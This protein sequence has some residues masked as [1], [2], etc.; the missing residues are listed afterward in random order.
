MQLK[1]LG[2]LELSDTS[3]TRVK[4][5]LLL[6]YLAVEGPK[7]RR[8]I[9]EL[10]WMGASDPLNS[11]SR[12]LSQLRKGASGAIEADDQRVWTSL[13]TDLNAFNEALT[14]KNYPD[15]VTHYEGAF[16]QGAHL[17][18]WGIELEE[19]IFEKREHYATQAQNALLELAEQHA[20]RGRFDDAATLAE[21][22]YTLE[23]ATES[24]PEDLPRYF[25]LLTAANHPLANKLKDEADQFGINLNL[26]T[27]EAQS[28]LQ[29][30]FI[31][32]ERERIKLENLL[33]GQ[34][35][36]VQG[37]PAM[38]K[39]SLLKSIS[40]TYLEA[41]SGL[42]YATL[43]PLLGNNLEDGEELI[44]RKLASLTGRYLF[45]PWEWM[46]EESQT[47]LKR[48]RDLKPQASIVIAS[49]HKAAFRADTELELEPLKQNALEHLEGAWEQTEGLPSLVGAFL[50]NEP[51]EDALEARLNTLDEQTEDVYL[52][53]AL[54]EKPN[55]ALV[56]RALNLSATHMA[57]A[58]QTLISTGL[59][60]PAGNIRAKQAAQDHLDEQTL[61]TPQLAIN[62]AR[63]LKDIEAY[64]LYSKSKLFWEDEDEPQIIKAYAAWANELLK[65]G[66]PQRASETLEDA[67][68]NDELSFLKARALE[69]A[70]LFKE[71]LSE[72]D[73]LRENPDILAL[74]GAL[75][76]RLG[77]P[78]E[79]KEASEKALDG[80]MEA[81]A[82]AF[83]TLGHLVRSEGDYEKATVFAKRSSALWKSL[84]RQTRW[85]DALNNLAV[86]T[87]LNAEDADTIFQ[88]ALEVAA[89]N[90]LLKARIL[91]NLG[92]VLDR[93]TKYSL[94]EEAYEKAAILSEQAGN[95]DTAAL[96]WNNIGV[97]HHRQGNIQKASDSYEKALQLAQ[98]AGEKRLLGMFMANLAEL[99]EDI[100][101]W[102][103]AL[104]ILEAS[105]HADEAEQ[106][107]LDLP[108]DHPFKLQSS[109]GN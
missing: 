90:S 49:Q 36:W 26:K 106:Y 87:A 44:L 92:M 81:R 74:K 82:E 27:N 11:L 62:L 4:P 103:E 76:W 52:S 95:R 86:A 100:E 65:R 55:P 57:S 77:K 28:R 63:H 46:D 66:F 67:P 60:D 91:T 71:A 70:G 6:S 15:A 29:S 78:E 97:L 9:A 64:P 73:G 99:T 18:D 105:G 89:D 23:G 34:F 3:F 93:A 33:H 21:R 47:I 83:N 56:R 75:Y 104:H 43:E 84:G 17:L 54:L 68:E 94:A 14:S 32:R 20:A 16:L 58:L 42:P 35:A 22:A 96:A 48:L 53:L 85:A 50:R 13:K 80:D 7:E 19:W 39:T 10:F 88:E 1:T 8:F 98:K 38:G 45:D 79:A 69:R 107:K 59:A 30:A 41:R 31:G 24:E 108:E 102:R 25:E 101:A 72:L 61:R 51:L 37:A 5:L 109:N 2:K 12:A 40:G